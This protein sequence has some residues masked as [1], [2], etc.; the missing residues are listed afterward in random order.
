MSKVLSATC[1][2][3]IVTAEAVPVEVTQKL[4][5]GVAASEGFILMQGDKVFYV[6]K[7][8]GDLKTTLQK[9]SEVLGNISSALSSLDSAGFLIGATAGVPSPPIL[10]ADIAALDAVIEE[11]DDLAENLK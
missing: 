5:E 6:A 8:S 1:E 9:L 2:E 11:I 4:C 3:G 10:A 7:T